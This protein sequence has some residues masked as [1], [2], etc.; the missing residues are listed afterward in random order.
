MAARSWIIALFTCC[1]G[2]FGLIGCQQPQAPQY[3]G[4]QHLQVNQIDLEK[5]DLFAKAL[6]YNPNGFNMELKKAEMDIFLNDKPANHYL[7]DSTISIPA[8]DSFWVPVTLRINLKSIF[9][10]AFQ[11]LLNDQVKIRF[12]G[13][14]QVKKG[15]LGFRVPIHYEESHTLSSLFQ[16]A[17]N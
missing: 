3:I 17:V 9:A 16:A 8:K 15:G 1:L 5:S 10:N 12:E 14:A 13:Y 7:L 6:F 2:L 4:L 11:S